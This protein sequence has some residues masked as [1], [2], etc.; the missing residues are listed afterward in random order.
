MLTIPSAVV[1]CGTVKE[2]K[3]SS[4]AS[5]NQLVHRADID[6]PSRRHISERTMDISQT[7]LLYTGI[8]QKAETP[9]IRKERKEKKEEEDA[10]KSKSRR[11][12]GARETL[13]CQSVPRHQGINEAPRH[14]D[15]S[16]KASRQTFRRPCL[17]GAQKKKKKKKKKKNRQPLPFK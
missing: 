17:S 10:S 6:Q 11:K 5:F 2:T 3:T 12:K 14:Q 13:Y 15:N 16:I 7:S 9:K 4:N 8:K 1:I